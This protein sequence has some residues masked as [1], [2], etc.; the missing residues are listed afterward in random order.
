[1]LVVMWR[2]VFLILRL[3]FWFFI[4][5]NVVKLLM[6]ILIVVMIMI[7]YLVMGFGLLRCW[8]VL[9][10]MV[11]IVISKKMVLKRVVKIDEFLYLYVYLLLVFFCLS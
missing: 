2:K 7:F 6:M 9:I 4:K 11:L 5:S 3:C 8:M 10:E 1:M